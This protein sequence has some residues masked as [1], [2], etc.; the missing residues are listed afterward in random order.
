MKRLVLL[1]GDIAGLYGALALTLA[2]RYGKDYVSKL[3]MHLVP[4]SI[5]F[6]FWIII[7]FIFNLYDII[8]AKNNQDYFRSLIYVFVINALISILFFYLIPFLGI[9]P[10]TN[11]FIFMAFAGILVFL[12]RVYFN[13]ITAQGDPDNNTLIIGLTKQSNELYDFLLANPQLGYKAIGIVDIED[14]EALAI[15]RSLIT[16]KQVRTLILSPNAYEMPDVIDILYGFLGYN[17][18]FYNLPDFYELATG[19]IPL[20]AINQ[21]WFL[22]NLSSGK[23]RFDIFTRRFF[24]VLF[25]L[26]F[27]AISLI[28]YPFIIFAVKYDSKGPIFIKQ[29]RLG[30]AGKIFTL[31]KFRSMI[32]NAPDGSA[33]AIT[34]AT[35]AKENDPRITRIGKFLRKT[36]L[37]ELPQLW[38]VLWGDMSFIGPRAERPEFHGQ[39]KSQIPFYNERYLIKPGLTGWAQ[40]RYPYGSSVQDATEKLQYDLFYIKNRSLALDISIIL[41]TLSTILFKKGR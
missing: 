8:A 25:S 37:D 17:I 33:E 3:D 26:V 41:K 31:I 36:R 2:V 29:K 10:K 35:W 30:W 4:F 24:D 15:L 14:K 19:K 21:E 12:W 1:M 23:K 22:D 40:I 34:G 11:L 20:S 13:A 39:L 27:G 16:K 38:N 32:A 28:F 5:I 18:D 6:I 9:T 7:F